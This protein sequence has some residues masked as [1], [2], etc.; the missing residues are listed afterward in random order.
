MKNMHHSSLSARLD[1]NLLRVFDAIAQ[2]RNLARAAEHLHLSPSAVSHALSRLRQQLDDPLFER[3]GRGV[4]PTALA[5]R[6]TPEIHDALGRLEAALYRAHPFDPAQDLQQLRIAMPDELEPTLLPPLSARLRSAAP[7]ARLDSVR[8]DRANLTADLAAQRLD[9]AVDVVRLNDPELR[10]QQ[11]GDDQFCVVS[12]AGRRRLTRRDYLAA[13]HVIVS[14]RR[15]GMALEDLHLQQHRISRQI[16]LRC[17]L[18]EAACEIVAGSDLL[19]TLP[20]HHA[21]AARQRYPLAC[22][23]A[24]VPLPPA[25]L[26]CTWHRLRDADPA[27]RWLRDQLPTMAA[28]A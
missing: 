6:L 19:L 14:S 12:R 7:Q 4:T 8:I 1:L 9:L 24:P 5:R 13:R 26:F 20:R 10:Q 2:Q 11:I 27:L 17:Q 15:S 28:A 21:D 25:A 3:H 23:A 16:A 18:L 22:F